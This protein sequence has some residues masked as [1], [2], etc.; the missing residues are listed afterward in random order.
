VRW[1]SPVAAFALAV[2]VVASTGATAQATTSRTRNQCPQRGTGAAPE[3]SPSPAPPY[4]QAVDAA[5]QRGLQVWVEA[6]LAKRWWQ[7]RPSFDAGV[8]RLAEL[9][10]RPG[11]AGFKIA[12]ELGYTDSYQ[13]APACMLTF[14]R[15]AAKALHKAS[16]GRKL[17]VDFVV[18]EL[19]CAPGVGSVA[20][21][22]EQCRVSAR[23]KYPAITLDAMDKVVRSRALDSI[24]LSTGLLD[25]TT[26]QQWGIDQLRAQEA[27]WR[28]VAHRG[29]K[30]NVQLNARKALAHPGAYQG[31]GTEANADASVFIDAP[32]RSG[33]R[34]VDVWT[35]R[36][37]YKGDI[38]RLMDPGMTDNALWMA[39][40]AQ[41]E[42]GAA[43]FTHFSPSSVERDVGGDLDVIARV[44]TGIFVAAGSG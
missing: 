8:Q 43:L 3:T 5:A 19:G 9:G 15:D 34:A 31:G 10:R 24:D 11:V 2:V 18:P 26:Y 1:R 42:K 41:R 4:E 33:A 12:D 21:E 30:R 17:L 20:S 14:L 22:T 16:P 7:G 13:T 23:A 36:Q 28:E 40:Q 37:Q 38:Y 29:W 32:T 35:W 44:F 39:L 6:D 27:A 25:A